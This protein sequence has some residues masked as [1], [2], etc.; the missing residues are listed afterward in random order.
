MEKNNEIMVLDAMYQ[1]AQYKEGVRQVVEHVKE[2]EIE[3]KEDAENALDIAVEAINL[4]EKIEEKRKEI[5]EPSRQ[6]QNEINRLAKEF[7]TNLEEVK[8][9]VIDGIEEWKL[10]SP[11]VGE[12]GTPKASTYEGVEFSYEVLDIASIPR[13][14]LKVDEG[15]IKLAMKQGMR[16]IPGLEI[17]KK[18]KTMLRR[19]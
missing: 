13:E 11:Q 16:K 1:I 12:L 9:T 2:I 5:I 7:T 4:N 17:C 3:T 15:M 10:R 14:F 19:R 18:T 6:F 8:T